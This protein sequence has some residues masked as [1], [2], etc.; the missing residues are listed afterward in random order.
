MET[1]KITPYPYQK[2]GIKKSLE[3][4]RLINGDDMGLGKTFEAIATIAVSGATPALVVCPSSLKINWEREIEK[5][6]N[7]R[8]LVLTDSIKATFPYYLSMK[9]YDV[10][11]VNYESLRKYFVIEAKTGFRLK[12]V[13]F[14]PS[15]NLF[16]SVILDES[17][18]CK[19]PS[20]QQTKFVRGICAGKEY[21][22][23]LTGTPVVNV[24]A[25]IA[26]QIAIMGRIKEFG[27][28]GKFLHD[29][30]ED[31]N[32]EELQQRIKASCYFRREKKDVLKDLPKLTRS[33]I[34][35]PISN[36]EEYETCYEDLK[37]Y[38]S[39][40]KNCSDDEIR[41]KMQM[42]AL[43]KFMNLRSIAS[44]G[45]VDAAI[46]F[47]RDISK[48]IVVFC[49]QHVIVDRLKEVFPDA[50]TVTGRDSQRLKQYAID[51]FQ[52][53]QSRIIICS[54][55]AAGVGITL[56]SGN[57]E[58]FI[59]LP[60]TYA[61]LTQCEARCDRI[62]QKLPVSSY[63]MLGDQTIDEHIYSLIMGKKSIASRITGAC[64]DIPNDEK[65]FN[66]LMSCI[67]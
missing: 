14:Q 3:Q 7:L 36:K 53:G 30:G 39:E 18:R 58:L 60:W 29:Y 26:T 9:M 35:T 15:I 17:H 51:S 22:I 46:D 47:I 49:S 10:T 24:P 8:P 57:E 2:E 56:T 52:K 37:K 64:D 44:L 20:A 42:K 5:F 32:L 25:D 48:Q 41:R 4:K 31:G 19:D 12:D 63:L 54:I 6:T 40:Y 50:V 43:V 11:I 65:Y 67:T 55:K 61:D 59:E 34:I 33:T 1:L 28:Y 13:I 38:L 66:E 45:K 23:M 21:V 27:G 62:G 16:K